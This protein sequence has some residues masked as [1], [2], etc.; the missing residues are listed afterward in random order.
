MTISLQAGLAATARLNGAAVGMK[1]L[2]SATHTEST[3][4]FSMGRSRG[5]LA[6]ELTVSGGACIGRFPAASGVV[7]LVGVDLL[8][9]DDSYA[10]SV[11]TQALSRLTASA[12]VPAKGACLGRLALAPRRELRRV[13]TPGDEPLHGPRF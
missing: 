6:L 8:P 1:A 4:N 10:A 2:V 13:F 7:A 9:H 3:T 12:L 5:D 11:R